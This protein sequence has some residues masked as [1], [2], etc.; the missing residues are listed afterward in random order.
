MKVSILPSCCECVCLFDASNGVV[1]VH[2]V[3]C[4]S[5]VQR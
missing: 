3:L 1:E 4:M 2:G 5:N